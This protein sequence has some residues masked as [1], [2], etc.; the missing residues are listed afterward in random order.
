M[1]FRIEKTI[2]A[3]LIFG[4]AVCGESLTVQARHEHLRNGVIGS[5]EIRENSISFEERGKKSSHAWEWKYEDIQ[6]ITLS[7]TELRILTYDDQKWKLGVDREYRFD[8]LPKDFAPQVYPLFS[9]RLDQRFVADLAEPAVKPLW[10]IP[11]KLHRRLGGSQGTILIGEDRI[12]YET[13]KG[14]S[15]TWRYR[16]IENISSSGLF[17]LS[18][19]TL[20]RAGWPHGAP[21]EYHFQL[22]EELSQDRY[23]DLWRRLNQ[24]Q[25]LQILRLETQRSTNLSAFEHAPAGSK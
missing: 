23:N 13:D 11:A 24:A 17:D 4:F 22:K 19:M 15:H 9:R 14:E 21:T 20:E 25:G 3:I 12:V 8:K 1:E 16:D 6:Q 18:I 2:G 7:P 5:L 10:K